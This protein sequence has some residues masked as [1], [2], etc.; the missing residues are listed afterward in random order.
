M[1]YTLNQ[2]LRDV[3]TFCDTHGQIGQYLFKDPIELLNDHESTFPVVDVV[4]RPA[5]V[6]RV[7]G[8]RVIQL[9]IEFFFLDLVEKDLSNEQEVLS[10][11]MQI[12]TDLLAYFDKREFDDKF[13]L[14]LN[15]SLN[16]EYGKGDNEMT[17]WSM[18]LGFNII[19][20]RDACAIP[21][22]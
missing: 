13:T 20:L 4:V 7:T 22:V 12:A 14:S 17:G 2:L 9:N 8:P 6:S 21:T 19:D 1:R 3:K 15:S 16:P 11:Q 10:D 18:V 5:S